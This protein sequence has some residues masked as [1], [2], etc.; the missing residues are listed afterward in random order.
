MSEATVARGGR[1]GTAWMT[2]LAG[3]L[4][5]GTVGAIALRVTDS[6]PADPAPVLV[7][8]DRPPEPRGIITYEVT[9]KGFFTAHA[10]G[11][12]IGEASADDLHHV[13]NAG[14]EDRVL[15]PDGTRSARIDR[16]DAGVF[17]AVGAPGH[18][19][20][21]GQIAGPSDPALVAGGKGHARAV[22]GVPLV[23]AW[24][25]DSKQLAYGSI[26]GEPWALQ[27]LSVS[28]GFAFPGPR[29]YEVEGGYVGELAWSP[30]GR[31]LAISTYS[32][33]RKNHTVLMLD[34]TT[35]RVDTVI[36][37]CHLTWSPDSRFLAIHRDPGPEA[38]AWI[39]SPDGDTRL[40]LSREPGA[41]PYT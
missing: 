41:F 10:S 40:A 4:L 11:E 17:L 33:D 24:S 20:M 1:A 27:V 32:L 35:N 38:G 37:G 28:S 6:P 7:V 30:D 19:Q 26:T 25:P 18:E 12:V 3:I 14:A 34:T 5:A 2:A 8:T 15:A 36:D 13:H 9:G 23:V 22:A 29:S 31:Y 21:V 39:I 16:T